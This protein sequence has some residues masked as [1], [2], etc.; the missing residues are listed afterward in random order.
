MNRLIPRI[1]DSLFRRRARPVQAVRADADWRALQSVNRINR[2]QWQASQ[3][4]RA[5]AAR[6]QGNKDRW[7]W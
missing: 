3:A 1:V 6:W 4:M 5:E 7:S 2:A